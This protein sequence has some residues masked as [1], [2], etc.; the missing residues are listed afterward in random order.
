M[1]IFHDKDGNRL[2][3]TE[4]EA[5]ALGYTYEH[6]MSEKVNPECSFMNADKLA[7]KVI[8]RYAEQDIAKYRAEVEELKKQL[9]LWRL[10]KSSEEIE[11]VGTNPTSMGGLAEPV[12]WML[13]GLEDRKPKLINLQVIEHLEGTWIP[14]YTHPAKTLTDEEILALWTQKNNLNGAKDVIDFARAILRKA[15]DN[16]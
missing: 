16:G 2:A 10:S 13:L 1:T 5:L 14:L 9:A 8:L 7:K 11:Q 4:A 15:Q 3:I 12:A 6:K